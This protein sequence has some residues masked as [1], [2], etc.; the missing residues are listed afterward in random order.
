MKLQKFSKFAPQFT[1]PFGVGSEISIGLSIFAEL[2]CSILVL[3]GLFA[4][5]A[6][7]PLIIN[8][9]VAVVVA[10]KFDVFGEGEKA[11]LFGIVFI[12]LLLT[13]PGKFS[14][15]RMIAK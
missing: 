15:D 1:D 3:L 13:G 6:C 4:R 14:L 12:T 9:A 2:V 8:M 10:H 7:I 11:A 5:L